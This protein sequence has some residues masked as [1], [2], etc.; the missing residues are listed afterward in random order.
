MLKKECE[1]INSLIQEA[2]GEQNTI[3]A[4][5]AARLNAES[6]RQDAGQGIL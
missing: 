2:R 4:A 3:R 6:A 5:Y 1:V